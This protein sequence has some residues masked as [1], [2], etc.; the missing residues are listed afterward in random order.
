MNRRRKRGITSYIIIFVLI[1]T[2]IVIF[3][4]FTGISLIPGNSDDGNEIIPVAINHILTNELSE[5]PETEKMDA[6]IE[7]FMRQW[8]IKGASLAVMKDEKLIYAKG[9]GWANKESGEKADVKHI[10]R[11][12]S[13][14]K[15]ITAAAVMKLH[16]EGKINLSDK[17]F[18]EGSIMD[19]PQFSQL[20]DSRIR[21]ITIDHLLRHK[22]GFS[23][24]AGDP[25]F[26]LPII[27]KRLNLGRAPDTDE[28]IAYSLN[29][30]LGHSPGQ[31]TRYSNLGYVILSRLIEIVTGL[32]YEEYVKENIFKPA[33]VYDIHMANN[34]YEERFPNEAK[35][36]EPHD[37]ELIESYTGNG[38]MMK[39]CYGG[40]NVRGLLGA[41]GWV[42]SPSELLKLIAALDGRDNVPDI[43]SKESIRI[44]TSSTPST[45]PIGWA[46]ST[47]SGDWSRTG[48]LSGTSALLKYSRD[49][50]SWVFVT[51]TSSWK[52]S[53]FPRQIDALFRNAFKRVPL[54]P[55]RDL[56][57][58]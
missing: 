6:Q 54:W 58:F 11:I 21:N 34:Y 28:V 43:L 24:R 52:G 27:S 53:T 1:L 45:L 29:Q 15:L 57:G 14:S 9:Y 4:G 3:F 42:A 23:S 8:E 32:S 26:N 36:Y 41:G 50:F 2:A 48:T 13:L 16:E 47:S 55:E 51:N 17:P 35:Y 25:M 30:R 49:G 40:N 7:R 31:G 33:G 5:L 56:F 12:A 38:I 22:G 10:F 44:M 18:S 37:Q 19:L 46:K 39:R 20:R